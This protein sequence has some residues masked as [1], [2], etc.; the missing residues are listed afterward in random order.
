[1]AFQ[2]ANKCLQN[3]FIVNQRSFVT[4]LASSIYISFSLTESGRGKGTS[5]PILEG[6]EMPL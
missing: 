5:V 4:S 6:S 1:M 2:L 3:L